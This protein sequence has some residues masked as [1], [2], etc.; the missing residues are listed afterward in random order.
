MGS[1]VDIDDNQLSQDYQLRKL[2]SAQTPDIDEGAIDIE[3]AG[4]WSTAANTWIQETVIGSTLAYGLRGDRYEGNY[5][6]EERVNPYRFWLD[7]KEEFQDM[8]TYIRAGKFEEVVTAKQF[9]DR[10]QRL[11]D[12]RDRRQLIANGNGYGMF[13]GG[14]ASMADLTTLIP[15]VGGVSKLSTM[16]KA[17]KLA[18]YGGTITAGQEVFL[19]R[20]QDLRTLEESLMNTAFATGL[21]G[22][23]GAAIGLFGK[24][25]VAPQETGAP[26]V[27]QAQGRISQAAQAAKEKITPLTDKL[28]MGVA[29]VGD[30]M[31]QAVFLRPVIKAGKKVYE[32]F[33][34]GSVGAAKVA[35][36]K[37]ISTSKATAAALKLA[38]ATPLGRL[39]TATSEK[40][41][42][43]AEKALDMGG[44][45]TDRMAGGNKQVSVEDLKAQL[46]SVFETTLDTHKLLLEDLR[47]KLAGIDPNAKTTGNQVGLALKQTQQDLVTYMQ[48]VGRDHDRPANIHE[49]GGFLDEWEFTYLTNEMLYGDIPVDDLV[50][51]EARFGQQ[52]ADMIIN[53][54][55]QQ[56]DN[57]HAANKLFE[58]KMVE[59]GMIREDQRMG[60]DYGKAQL[61]N[62]RFII[63]NRLDAKN[64]FLEVL[65]GQPDGKWL[66]ESYGMTLD[67]FADL[68]VIEKNGMTIEQGKVKRQEILSEWS[69]DEYDRMLLEA[70]VALDMAVAAEKASRKALMVITAEHNKR[71]TIIRRASNKEAVAVAKRQE[72][73]A[74][75]KR[76]ELM[77]WKQI[78]KRATASLKGQVVEKT[79][80]LK[81]FLDPSFDFKKLR[82]QR[83]KDLKAAEENL[84]RLI[85]EGA[86]RKDILAAED[87]V[88][89]A[90]INLDIEVLRLDALE[91]AQ[92][93]AD[94]KGVKF[95]EL[96]IQKERVRVAQVNIRRLNGEIKRLDTSIG[97]LN[98]RI[99]DAQDKRATA[100]KQR[101]TLNIMRQR[102]MAESKK[103]KKE[104]RAAQ[105]AAKAANSK[106]P[107]EV[108]VE[109]LLDKLTDTQKVPLGILDNM[110]FES[111]RAKSR[112]IILTND[113]RRHAEQIGLL[114]SDL[115]AVM[116]KGQED[117]STRLSM[118]EL[119]GTEDW[120]VVAKEIS[121]DYNDLI[122]QAKSAGDEAEVKRLTKERESVIK[123]VEGTWGRLMGT[124]GLGDP[125]SFV[126]W[127]AAKLREMTFIR[128]GAGF[129]YSSLT[130]LANVVMQSGFGTLGTKN[131]NAVSKSFKGMAF[132]EVRRMATASER[133]LANSRTL[134]VA[135]VDDIGLNAGIGVE[136][137]G[138]HKF[139]SV[140]DRTLGGISGKTNIV[141]LMSWWNTRLKALAMIE[142]QNNL[143]AKVAEYDD[144][145]KRADAGDAN[146]QM[147]VA[148]LA[149]VGLG[150]AE[151]QR[152][153][154]MLN[155]HKPI[156]K[157]GVL[158]LEINR[159]LSEGDEGIEAFNDVMIALRKSANRA[160]ATPGVGD[161]PLF[162][163][164]AYGKTLMQLQSYGFIT[165]N[166]Y[167][168]PA[169]QRG[170]EFGDV[171]AALSMAFS[172][173]LGGVVVAAKDMIRDGQIRDR[174][175]GQLMF[176]IMDRSGFLYY[177]SVPAAAGYSA[178]TGDMPSRYASQR[179]LLN[180]ALGPSASTLSELYGV[181]QGALYGDMDRIT[182]SAQR[183]MPWKTLTVDI[184]SVIIPD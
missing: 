21:S 99:A 6:G 80:R 117:L 69:G 54:A 77:K 94:S 53:A 30:A 43:Y 155:K 22:T 60:S 40:A 8:E 182:D 168:V 23:I 144:L 74:Q 118:R 27:S 47:L 58:D 154:K 131:F 157:D 91:L 150:R 7:N 31:G 68:G 92:V 111:G 170:A 109:E 137:S 9:A 37:V 4:F 159:W 33:V 134:Q 184:P 148:N 98:A 151:I 3:G 115:Y 88:T 66:E 113:Q 81:Q 152:I 5:Q 177:L 153:S 141:S 59:T 173:G 64:F 125:D 121:D 101:E 46:M 86:P 129:L 158:D 119:F 71:G 132:E 48:T 78:E 34:R 116:N 42:Q 25:P 10:A 142:M 135:N 45:L 124:Y 169:V 108:Y 95:P 89:Q 140:V 32:P 84:Q 102:V 146:A 15:V 176:D 83:R 163:S 44:I 90:D 13:V 70:E 51:L 126:Q 127:S 2:V 120:N 110:H 41:V 183:L 36:G 100:K 61:W 166:R 17:V 76:A 180:L 164:K 122:N 87:A 160:V 52:G 67:D 39:A 26:T 97:K 24:K 107:M 147:Q 104:T 123:D 133:V 62:S 16:G 57:I 106:T 65:Q 149:S 172:V 175:A 130:D 114:R 143:P 145:L 112:K 29:R 139:T 63:A 14:L 56:A 162:M 179:G 12:E 28:N 38:R 1:I 105:R 138:M 128:F 82:S 93:R 49:T 181:S 50:K 161:T 178:V 19:H 55:K 85:D 96:S 11:R 165:V 18:T 136:G 20:Q 79:F 167:L 73:N 72:K 75:R 174:S 103:A 35:T 156:E 171:E